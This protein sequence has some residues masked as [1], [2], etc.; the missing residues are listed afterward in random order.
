M[1]AWLDNRRFLLLL[2]FIL[3]LLP[4]AFIPLAETTEARYSEIAREMVASGNYLEPT[5]NGIKHFHKP[6]VAYWLIAAGLNI[7]GQNDFGARFFGVVAA[8]IA[9]AALFH[10]GRI[11]L[12]DEEKA[13]MAALIGASSLLF[14]AVARIAATDIY[15]TCFTLL[16]QVFLF[17]QIY[18]RK[19]PVNALL[20]ASFLALGFLTKGPIIFLFT[21]LPYLLAKIFDREH[22]QVFSG[23]EI[24]AAAFLFSTIAL[25]WYLAASAKNPGLLQYFLQV[26]TVDRVVTDRFH[27]Y[28]P[29][30]YFLEI[31]ALTFLPYIFFFLRGAAQPRALPARTRI[32]LV[33]ISVPFLV[34]SLAQGKHPTYILPLFGPP[35][36]LPPKPYRAFRRPA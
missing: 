21:L 2:Y 26:Q 6:P 28:E 16:A 7:F 9:V 27:R 13:F 19:S 11:I 31:F 35:P 20:Y 3:L 24:I 32:L 23:K 5:F 25:P 14:L 29:P 15:L 33:Y 10:L 4:T 12:A 1:A 22:R 8:V 36:S 17:R 18:G 34:F 30:W